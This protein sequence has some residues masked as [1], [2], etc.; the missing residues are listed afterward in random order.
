MVDSLIFDSLLNR[1]PVHGSQLGIRNYERC[2]DS[3]FKW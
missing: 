1:S 2:N 3:D